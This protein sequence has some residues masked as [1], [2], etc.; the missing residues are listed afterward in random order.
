LDVVL[1][2]AAAGD[3]GAFAIEYYHDPFAGVVLP[4]PEELAEALAG[5][6]LVALVEGAEVRPG[7]DHAVAV[8]NEEGHATSMDGITGKGTEIF[9]DLILLW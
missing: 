2:G 7:E 1:V 6:H 9:R 8:H 4:E 3:F 5:L